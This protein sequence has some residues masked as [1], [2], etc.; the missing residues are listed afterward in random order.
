MEETVEAHGLLMEAFESSRELIP[1][2]Q[3]TEVAFE[4]LRD[5]PVATVERIYADLAIDSWSQAQAP[6][7]RRAA[8]SRHYRPLPVILEPTAEQRL[9]TLLGHQ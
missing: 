6:I 3:L 1:S 8:Q 7:A 2:G 4:D 9:I 5:A